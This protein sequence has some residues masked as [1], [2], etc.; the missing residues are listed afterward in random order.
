MGAGTWVEKEVHASTQRSGGRKRTGEVEA[1][2]S[3]DVKRRKRSGGLEEQVQAL[4]AAKKLAGAVRIEGRDLGAKNASINGIY[5]LVDGGFEGLSAYEKAGGGQPRFLFYS[6]RKARW[7]INDQ[8]DDT[9]NGFAFAKVR[10]G[11]KVAPSDHSPALRWHVFD[12]KDGGYNEDAAVRC[13][14]VAAQATAGAVGDASEDDS[15]VSSSSSSSGSDAEDE[16]DSDAPVAKGKAATRDA[17]GAP[18]A[19][20]SKQAAPRKPQGRVCAKML[21]HAGLRCSCHFSLVG[22]CPGLAHSR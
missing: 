14:A 5:A 7:K 9:K 18:V 16:D 8:L 17:A 10:D 4:Q 12:G 2:A 1:G 3:Q 15:S 11:G 19:P 21:V 13:L 20:H 6:N 22:Q